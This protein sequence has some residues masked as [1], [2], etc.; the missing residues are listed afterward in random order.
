[1]PYYRVTLEDLDAVQAALM[2]QA[3]GLGNTQAQTQQSVTQLA[4]TTTQA[5]A[6]GRAT[7]TE[8][9]ETLAQEVTR[10]NELA[11]AAQWTGPDADTFR[12]ANADLLTVIDQTNLRFT[13]AVTQYEV[14]SQQL[15]ATL[16]ELVAEFT[17]ASQASQESSTQLS[18][19]VQIEA[20]SYE[21]AFNGSFAYGG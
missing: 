3:D 7:V 14:S 10:S 20:Q 2:T 19:A 21:E 5:L 15:M 16:D 1:M 12:Q 11:N 4:D 13:D 8:Q 9:L 18:S 17:V 6:T